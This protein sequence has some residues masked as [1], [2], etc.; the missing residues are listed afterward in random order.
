MSFS[1]HISSFVLLSVLR[2]SVCPFFC[3][4]F[5]FFIFFSGTHEAIFNQ[6]W[7]KAPLGEEGSICFIWR[8]T[9]FRKGDNYAIAKMHWRNLK[10]FLRSREPLGQFQP[11]LTQSILRSR[12]FKFVQM[13]GHALLQGERT[14]KNTLDKSNNLQNRWASF[15]QT[16]HKTSMSD[17]DSSYYS[18]FKK[19]IFSVSI[20]LMV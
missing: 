10:I 8:V 2:L 17:G 1:D 11:N 20:N 15:N 12:A 9:S 18:I 5:T 4:P 3:K 16:W 14:S 13:K 7:Y 19:S 6:T